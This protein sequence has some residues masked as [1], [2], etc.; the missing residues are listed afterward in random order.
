MSSLI[1]SYLDDDA[2]PAVYSNPPREDPDGTVEPAQV[3][4]H[5]WGPDPMEQ[6]KR[7]EPQP[8]GTLLPPPDVEKSRVVMYFSI[9]EAEVLARKLLEVVLAARDGVYSEF[10]H[11]MAEYSREQ[12][13]KDAWRALGFDPMDED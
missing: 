13:L 1:W 3:V 6:L 5:P 8:D 9:D 4:L 10:G 7:L 2:L 11:H 12:D